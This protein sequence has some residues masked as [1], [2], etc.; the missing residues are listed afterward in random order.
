VFAT[1]ASL[2]PSPT[3]RCQVHLELRAAHDG[4]GSGVKHS[5]RVVPHTTGL[6][7]A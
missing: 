6:V 3:R 1:H 4:A 5:T 2:L 7:Q